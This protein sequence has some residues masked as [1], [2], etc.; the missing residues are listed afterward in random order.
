MLEQRHPAL[1]AYLVVVLK[2]A[3]LVRSDV[4]HRADIYEDEDFAIGR[5]QF[6]LAD[7]VPADRALALVAAAERTLVDRISKL[8]GKDLSKEESTGRPAAKDKEP[9]KSKEKETKAAGGK[10]ET[11]EA[12]EAREALELA[13]QAKEWKEPTE[14]EVLEAQLCRLRF[15]RALYQAHLALLKLSH[16]LHLP[17]EPAQAAAAAAAPAAADAAGSVA[18]LAAAAASAAPAVAAVPAAA[19]AAP[20]AAP[21]AAAPSKAAPVAGLAELAGEA[22]QRPFVTAREQLQ[23]VRASLAAGVPHAPAPGFDRSITR[24]IVPTAPPR[25]VRVFP[26]LPYA[27]P[28]VSVL[29]RH[30]RSRCR[31]TSAMRRSTSTCACSSNCIVCSSLLTS[32]SSR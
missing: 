16:P 24:N 8:S 28:S 5:F 29:N 23:S 21:A 30:L 14:A 20:A 31:C 9:E 11:K 2:T 17:A 26:S 12:K 19:A 7:S 4:V 32:P 27:A 18:V 6:D 1:H 15:R 3:E 13:R 25:D 10:E 22:A